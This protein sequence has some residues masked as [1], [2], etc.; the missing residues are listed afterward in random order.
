MSMV[1]QEP[2]LFSGTVADNIRYN[3]ESLSDDEVVTAAKTVGAHD[4][5]MSLDLSYSTVLAERGI[6]LSVGQRQLLSFARA[7]AGD[8][9]VIILDEAT[10][11]IDTHTEVLIQQALQEVLRGRTSIVIA[12]RLSTVRNADN[13]VVLD[14]GRLVEQG[15]HDELLAKKGGIYARLYAVNYGL[16][17]DDEAMLLKATSQHD[18]NTRRRLTVRLRHKQKRPALERAFFPHVSSGYSSA[19]KGHPR[20]KNAPWPS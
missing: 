5:I 8:P 20:L 17:V 7:V 4:F 10:A 1:L 3:N 18:T 11:N 16:P 19:R 9:R 15:N 14:Q 2:Y 12:H 6:N 13:I